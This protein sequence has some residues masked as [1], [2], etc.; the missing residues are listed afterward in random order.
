[1]TAT[2]PDTTAYVVHYGPKVA[3]AYARRAW[4]GVGIWLAIDIVVTTLLAITFPENIALLVVVPLILL[5]PVLVSLHAAIRAPE[6]WAADGHL[7]IAIGDDGVT[8]PS[9]GMLPW[10]RITGVRHV[11]IGITTGNVFIAAIQFWNGTRD[12]AYLAVFVSD[13]LE[14]LGQLPAPARRRLVA[15][16]PNSTWGFKSA[17]RQGLGDEVFAR[18]S[19]QLR[20]AA[21]ARGIPVVP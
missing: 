3:H 16:G 5:I 17:L 21:Q 11:D 8:L 7:A 20:A 2:D 6:K 9:V 14:Q 4:I 15:G 19:A 12:N 10:T 18:A 13:S 1:M